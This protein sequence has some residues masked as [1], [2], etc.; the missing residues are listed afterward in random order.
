MR[1]IRN[2]VE[3]V[4]KSETQIAKLKAEGFEEMPSMEATDKQQEAKEL[5]EMNTQELKQVAKE[6]G[7]EGY[8]GL[9]KE[10]LLEVLKDVV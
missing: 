2:N 6:R 7:I 3:R 1:L 8:S 10:E 9:K 4:A 5:S